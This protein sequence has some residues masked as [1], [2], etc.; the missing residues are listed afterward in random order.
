[1]GASWHPYAVLDVFTHVPLE[2][3]QLAIFTDASELTAEQMQRTARELHLSET[4]F[5]VGEEEEGVDARIRIF[6]P[7]TELPFAGHPVLGTAFLLGHASGRPRVRLRTGAGLI[8]VALTREDG[9][10]VF[11]E[12]QQALPAAQSF[13]PAAALLRALGVDRSRLPVQAYRNGPLHVYVEIET[14]EALVALSPDMSALAGLGELGIAC[15]AGGRGRLRMRYF[16]PALGVTEDPA[17][18]S[19]AGPLALHL[20]RHK[21]MK[22]AEALEIHQGLEIGRPSVI[23]ARVEG[24]EG[25]IERVLVGGSA[26]LVGR[27]RYRLR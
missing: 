10:I 21:R 12:M 20:V 13:A 16:A 26:V 4:V 9:E 11:G 7:A 18:G 17:T 3:N 6:T 23:S 1:M 15:F 22:V 14:E 24:A 2:G 8:P 27:G 19:A 5:V 25:R